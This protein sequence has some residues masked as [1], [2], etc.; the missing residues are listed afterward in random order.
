MSKQLG[1]RFL[2]DFEVGEEFIGYYVVRNR[3][4]RTRKNGMPYL[5]LEI[6]DRSGRLKG[7]L[8][9]D[10]EMLIEQM[11]V[12]TVVKVKGV[13]ETYQGNK[14]V[15]FKLS[16]TKSGKVDDEQYE[17]IFSMYKAALKINSDEYIVLYNWGL[18]LYGQADKKSNTKAD[19][20]YAEAYVKFKAAVKLK[21][22]DF[23]I[24]YNWGLSL[25]DQAVKKLGEEADD[26]FAQAY[27]ILR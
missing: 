22:D 24:L 23:K 13:I 16:Q 2:K 5:T 17:Q 11:A 9:D 1:G 4:L 14:Q 20:L 10:A 7:N 27:T 19:D 6:G 15:T 25:S 3:D 26:L 18:A 12:D 8:W 21:P